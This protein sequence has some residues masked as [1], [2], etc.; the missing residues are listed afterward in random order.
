[1]AQWD[2]EYVCE[3]GKKLLDES[4]F[5]IAMDR[6]RR[7]GSHIRGIFWYQGCSDAFEDATVEAFVPRMEQMVAAFRADCGNPTLPFVQ[8]QICRF[9]LL[10]NP[11]EDR[12]WMAIKELQ[13]TLHERIPYLDTVAVTNATM[14]DAIHLSTDSQ[15]ILGKNACE[16]MYHLCF[17]PEGRASIPA[18]QPGAAPLVSTVSMPIFPASR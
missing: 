17:D 16:S 15:R 8:V 11:E 1:M 3:D 5:R 12:T 18:P 6:F 13:R 14:S 2:P 10:T 7:A 4:L 9:S